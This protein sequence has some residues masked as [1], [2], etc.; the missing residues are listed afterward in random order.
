[1]KDL[2]GKV[3]VVTGGGGAIGEAFLA[4]GMKV[5][6]ADIVEDP[7]EAAVR[8][9]G[10][11]DVIGIPTDVNVLGVINGMNAFLPTLAAQDEG[12]VVNTSLANGGFTP[13][14]RRGRLAAHRIEDRPCP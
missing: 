5:V 6:L 11:D 3:A 13:M 9:I 12:H 7:L 14:A 8:D 10:S 4:E 1:M 2:A